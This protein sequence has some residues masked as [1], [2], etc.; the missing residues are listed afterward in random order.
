MINVE[1]IERVKKNC[2]HF[3]KQEF[4]GRPFVC[5]T[6]PKDG[7]TQQSFDFSYVKRYNEVKNGNYDGMLKDYQK[8][9]K[10][11][12]FGGEALPVYTADFAPDGYAS[13][14]GGEI[15]AQDGQQTT[16]VHNIAENAKDLN[17][18]FDENNHNFKM[19]VNYVKYAAEFA[20]GDFLIS[21]LD[22]HGNLDALSALLDPQN[23]CI[24]LF[25]NPGVVEEK[26]NQ[27]NDSYQKIYN[28]IYAAGNMRELGTVGWQPV[29]S[30]GKS[31]VLQ[32]DFSCMISPDM[33]RKYVIPSIEREAEFLD[34]SV[35]HYDGKQALG[36]FEDILAIKKIN[37][38]QWVPGDGEKRTLYWPDLLK[39]IQKAG[40]SVWIYD[41]TPEEILADK[42]LIPEK[43]VF[44]VYLP[45]ETEAKKFLEKLERKYK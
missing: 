9:I 42:E 15:T 8:C 21:M 27:I 20:K 7:I 40:K 33:A 29:Y 22:L 24:E 37:C 14:F 1:N 30:A 17:C 34:N 31:A 32:C 2:G 11:V 19:L 43:T 23:L 13:F 45:S 10:G 6:A 3:W 5:V 26:L 28:S 12:Y 41:W 18:A 36:H 39:R 35:Y 44:S 25:D 4:I 38:V 16:W